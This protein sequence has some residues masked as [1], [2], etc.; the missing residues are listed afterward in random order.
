[1]SAVISIVVGVCATVIIVAGVWYTRKPKQEQ[2]TVVLSPRIS[3][4]PTYGPIAS[5][6]VM[7]DSADDYET[8]P[9]LL[10]NLAGTSTDEPH[11][12]ETPSVNQYEIPSECSAFTYALANMP[13]TYDIAGSNSD[14]FAP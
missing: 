12:Y 7:Y 13:H 11:F 14:A 9:E 3:R 8:N 5:G 1:M 4:N 6:T 2:E 10:Y